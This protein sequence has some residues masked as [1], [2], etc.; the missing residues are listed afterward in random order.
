[1]AEITPDKLELLRTALPKGLSAGDSRLAGFPEKPFTQPMSWP[2]FQATTTDTKLYTGSPAITETPQISQSQATEFTPHPWKI[3]LR[4]ENDQTQY[5]VELNSNLY[6]SLSNWN[7]ISI[8]GLD[9]WTSIS[10]GFLI[11]FGIVEDGICTSASIQGP[12]AVPSDRIEFIDNLQN[13]FAV[14]LAYFY[15]DENN[16]WIVRQLAFQDLTL[17]QTCIDGNPSIY[18]FSI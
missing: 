1:M 4:T 8:N 2:Q 12:Q 9:F 16:R 10:A 7:N 14:Q 17:I 3:Y 11:L 6:S 5:K 18:P 13:T 15:Q